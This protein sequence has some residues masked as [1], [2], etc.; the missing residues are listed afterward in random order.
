MINIMGCLKH[1]NIIAANV[2][3]TI[4]KG[5]PKNDKNIFVQLGLNEAD[6]LKSSS[7]L[8]YSHSAQNIYTQR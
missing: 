5:H 6:M 3:I 7:I 1:F 4:K 2:M 8:I